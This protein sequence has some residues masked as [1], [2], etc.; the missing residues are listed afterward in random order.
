MPVV[1]RPAQAEAADR[2]RIEPTFL[3][4][5]ARA[6]SHGRPQSGFVKGSG[7]LCRLEQG[8]LPLCPFALL[9]GCLRDGQSRLARELLD[10]LDEIEIVGTH[11]EPDDV[12]MRPASEAMKEGFI[13][14]DVE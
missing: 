8:L 2:V 3:Q 13:L 5:L 10:R 7:G 14:D 11:D 6:S 1:G 4:I 12:A 9:R